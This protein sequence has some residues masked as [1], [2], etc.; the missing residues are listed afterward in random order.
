VV[1]GTDTTPKVIATAI[2]QLARAPE[3]RARLAQAPD[4]IP[5]AF[6]EARRFE[7]PTQ[8]M[9][10]SVATPFSLHDPR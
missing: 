9:A 5:G 1:G 3:Q 6:M 10:R 2:Q 7:M 4:G 8:F